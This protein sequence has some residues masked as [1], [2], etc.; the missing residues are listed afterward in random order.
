MNL[1]EE[2]KKRYHEIPIP[3]ELTERV[4]LEIRLAKEKQEKD[5]RRK[6]EKF[7]KRMLFSRRLQARLRPRL[8]S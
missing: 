3:D 1:F 8:F 4:Q 7:S 5:A 2:A 6:M